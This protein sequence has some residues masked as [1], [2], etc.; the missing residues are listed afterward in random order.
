MNSFMWSRRILNQTVGGENTYPSVIPM[1][2]EFASL[3]AKVKA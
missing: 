1:F 3:L 2:E